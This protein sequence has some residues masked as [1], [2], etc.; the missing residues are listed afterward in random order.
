MKLIPIGAVL[1]TCAFV[2]TT[3]LAQ[4]GTLDQVSPFN[5]GGSGAWF[6]VDATTLT[7]QC[8]VRVGLAGPLEG[9]NLKLDGP[10]GA[11]VDVSVR[12]G[13]GWNTGAIAFTTSPTPI[14][15]A[16]T[17]YEVVFVNT[18]SAGIN[19]NVGDTFV[20]ELHGNGTQCGIIGSY[21]DPNLGPALYPEPLFLNGPGCFAGCGWRIGFETYMLT[22]APPVA[23]CTAGTTSNN[24]LASISANANPKVT[25]SSPCQVSV[26]N[27]EGQRAGILFYGLAPTLQPWCSQG[28]G[29][30]LLCVKAPTK[31]TGV[32]S[33]G[34]AMNQC[35]G[36]L[37]L[38]WNAFQ[39]ANPGALGAPWI[40]GS[41]AYVQ[42]WFRD[43]LSCKT[44]S[45]SNA[46]ELTYQP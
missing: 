9:F 22:S 1:V 4:T 41:K 34:G 33:S 12:I 20:I 3:A 24:C 27:V 40:A 42:G 25:Y 14:T 8:Q 7:W 43:P 18:T 19:L 2:S 16:L 31:R 39:L 36:S 21:I 15:K 28:G 10:A 17:G 35:N 32:Q 6:N 38:D 37:G 11:Q 46:L 29:S 23:Y 26:V 30:S 13:D 44:T 45:L 5:G